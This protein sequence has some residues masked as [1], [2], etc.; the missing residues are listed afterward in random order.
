MAAERKDG[1][2]KRLVIFA[3]GI[4]AFAGAQPVP[5]SSSAGAPQTQFK[6]IR[7]LTDMA[8]ADVRKEMQGFTVALGVTCSYCHN[9][10]NFA[11]DEKPKKEIARK[12]LSMV[13]TM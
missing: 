7:V 10:T 12:M 4:L 13:R 5:V 3:C 9:E 11:S 2:V 1:R 8:D 6:N